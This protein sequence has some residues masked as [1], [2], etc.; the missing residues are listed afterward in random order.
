MNEKTS[1][2]RILVVDDEP[3]L[4]KLM[5]TR[6]RASGYDVLTSV[7]APEGLEK[8][9]TEKPDLIILDVMMPIVN[10]YNFCRLLKAS[11]ENKDIPII[12]LTSR[13]GEEDKKIGEEVGANAYLTKPFKIDELLSTI[14]GFVG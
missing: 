5:E 9:M 13:T 14:K 11:P 2:K 8:A 1:Q 4:I 7:E 6:L 10:G 3:S 12:F